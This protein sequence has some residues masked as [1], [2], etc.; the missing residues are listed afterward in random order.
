[1]R[2]SVCMSVLA[3]AGLAAAANAQITL[4]RLATISLLDVTANPN[5][6]KFIGQAGA[7]VAW[8]GANLW[9]GGY[10]NS[11]AVGRTA[12]TKI[13]NVYGVPSFGDAF[14]VQTHGTGRGY[15]SM[16]VRNGVLLSGFEGGA[17][18]DN[19]LAAWDGSQTTP[20]APNWGINGRVGSS[21]FDPGFNASGSPLGSGFGWNTFN[22]QPTPTRAL[23]DI[24][25]GAEIYSPATGGSLGTQP[26]AGTGTTVQAAI[27]RGLDFDPITGDAWG[28]VNNT[29][30]RAIRTGENTFSPFAAVHNPNLPNQFPNQEGQNLEVVRGS[31]LGDLVF[32]N[33][34]ASGAG[35]QTWTNAFRA[36]N[37]A[38]VNQP[39]SYINFNPAD[40]TNNNIGFFDFSYDART[41]TLAVLSFGDA[42]GQL[43]LKQV[44]IFSI[45]TPGAAA[46]LG[47]GGLAAARRR[48]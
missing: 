10:N 15:R 40:T 26:F 13:S 35:G 33:F 20:A 37:L 42:G 44:H 32:F 17:N 27:P 3:V 31:P 38:G 25:T 46:L 8:D 6:P 16:A 48:R 12:I 5:S 41:N 18:F 1:M 2:A 28:R 29:V 30:A 39:I 14:G 11:G 22:Q 23:R 7:S 47:L 21:D 4:E 19:A 34:R 9:V 24:T 45:P 36:I 43:G